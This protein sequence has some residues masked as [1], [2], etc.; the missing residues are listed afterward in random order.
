MGPLSYFFS[1]LSGTNHNW[2]G[3][4]IIILNW[5]LWTFQTKSKFHGNNF[6]S[7]ETQMSVVQVLWQVSVAC[8]VTGPYWHGDV[9][10]VPSYGG[11]EPADIYRLAPETASSPAP[12]CHTHLDVPAP[13][14]E[15]PAMCIMAHRVFCPTYR[16]VSWPC[17]MG[18]STMSCT[19]KTQRNMCLYSH[20]WEFQPFRIMSFSLTAATTNIPVRGTR[21][22]Q[23]SK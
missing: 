23:F 1:P 19:S 22:S 20:V 6:E 9:R 5:L 2:K 3:N 17:H 12:A 15:D 8:L 21:K 4:T 11:G 14:R 18:S 16:K 7:P 13:H 10:V